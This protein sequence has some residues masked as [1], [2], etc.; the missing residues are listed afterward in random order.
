M[1]F[2]NNLIPISIAFVLFQRM[3]QDYTS[4][5]NNFR[6]YM[7]PSQMVSDA[8]THAG[9][10]PMPPTSQVGRPVDPIQ[11]QFLLKKM[12]TQ[13]ESFNGLR[14]LGKKFLEASSTNV[15]TTVSTK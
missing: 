7:P 10:P 13:I 4:T 15:N 8:S 1:I 9:H 3:L 5:Q 11:Y 6:R 12:E 14:E 2:K